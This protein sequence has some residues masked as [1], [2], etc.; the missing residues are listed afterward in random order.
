[1]TLETLDIGPPYKGILHRHDH[2]AIVC[3]TSS[4]YISKEQKVWSG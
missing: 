4:S 1:M 2:T 3:A